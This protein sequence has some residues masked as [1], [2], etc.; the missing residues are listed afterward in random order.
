MP[1]VRQHFR[2]F[3][4][5][6]CRVLQLRL[7]PQ[8]SELPQVASWAPEARGLCTVKGLGILVAACI[9]RSEKSCS[10]WREEGG[11]QVCLANTNLLLALCSHPHAPQVFDAIVSLAGYGLGTEDPQHERFRA[12]QPQSGRIFRDFVGRYVTRMAKVPVVLAVHAWC[13][14]LSSYHDDCTIIWAIKKQARD[15]AGSALL[16]TRAPSSKPS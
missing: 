4:G 1:I 5:A 12:P 15:E 8:H 2:R 7:R 11:F 16:R 10:S 6:L 13:D 3:L 14:S 9:Y